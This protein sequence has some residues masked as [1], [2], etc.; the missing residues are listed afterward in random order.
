MNV[1]HSYHEILYL[2]GFW[3]LTFYDVKWPLTSN[4]TVW[5]LPA[6]WVF[7]MGSAS[8]IPILNIVFTRLKVSDLWKLQMT[9]YLHQEKKTIWNFLVK[10]QIYISSMIV[11]ENKTWMTRT[12][13]VS[14]LNGIRSRTVK[15]GIKEFSP[16]YD[17]TRWLKDLFRH[18]IVTSSST[19]VHN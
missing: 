5:T 4:K 7:C 17:H 16:Q 13:E 6:V 18:F 10:W 12:E 15:M 1:H 9:T 3:L 11:T 8:A 19:R 2:Q 14:A